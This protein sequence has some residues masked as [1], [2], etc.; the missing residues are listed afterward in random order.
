[1]IKLKALITI[2]LLL[3]INTVNSLK[4]TDICYKQ[5][6][7]MDKNHCLF[8]NCTGLLTFDCNRM[9]CTLD[10]ASCN[11]YQLGLSEIIKRKNLKLDRASTVSLIQGISFTTKRL[12]GFSKMLKQITMC[13][14]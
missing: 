1:M 2:I 13:P 11:E 5:Y 10:F 12:R 6:E 3:I 7:C 8:S 4:S 9:E 14:F